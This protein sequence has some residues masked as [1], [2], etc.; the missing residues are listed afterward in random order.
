VRRPNPEEAGTLDLLVEEAR[1]AGAE[2]ALA[3]DPDADRLAVAIPDR[4]ADGGWRV[5]TGDETGAL[6]ADH[7]LRRTPPRER[8]GRLLVTTVASSTLL[9][10]IAAAAGVHSATTL[11][12]FK[13][14]MRAPA[15]IE[16]GT[17][18]LFG[19]EEAIG[20]AVT[21]IVRDK[22]GISAAL[23]VAACAEDAA[24]EGLT[25]QD[26]LDDLAR[27]FGVHA[28]SQVA[29]ELTGADGRARMRAVMEGLQADPPRTLCGRPVDAVED[30]LEEGDV[31][32]LRSGEE[33]RAVIRPSGTEPKL[34]IYLQSVVAVTADTPLRQARRLAAE[35]LA[36][37]ERELRERT[38][39]G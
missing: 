28:T 37:L 5:L 20:F 35:R 21:D 4:E 26:R 1:A 38:G 10:R 9:A 16:G 3:T 30:R 12:G 13:W 33:V 32:I 15:T 19:Y 14:I 29:V 25:L 36:E 6:L 11:T 22:D 7:V 24:A 2:L 8:T 27:R 17:G 39:L 18:V 23:A 34:K 31:L